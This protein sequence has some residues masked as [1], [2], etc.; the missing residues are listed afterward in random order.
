MYR[1]VKYFHYEIYASIIKIYASIIMKTAY[2]VIDVVLVSL[3]LTLNKFHTFSVSFVDF[4]HKLLVWMPVCLGKCAIC[5]NRVLFY[6]QYFRHKIK[7]LPILSHP[8]SLIHPL[9]RLFQIAYY[10]LFCP[11]TPT[12]LLYY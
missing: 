9:L 6:C 10:F 11:T 5:A 1:R 4:K 3:L 8:S 7:F 12:P 2:D